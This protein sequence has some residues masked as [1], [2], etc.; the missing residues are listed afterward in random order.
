M[1]E[2][3]SILGSILLLN[4]CAAQ[5]DSLQVAKVD[6]PKPTTVSLETLTTNQGLYERFD[7]HIRNIVADA[8]TIKFQTDK[9]DFVYCRSNNTW[10]VQPGTI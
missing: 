9:N 4:A 7:Y 6:C 2:L 5:V 3:V 1:K 10:T 8:S